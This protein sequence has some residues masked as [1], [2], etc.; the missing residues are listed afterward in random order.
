MVVSS[1]GFCRRGVRGSRRARTSGGIDILLL[2]RRR[3]PPEHENLLVDVVR[4][5][6][7]KEVSL[8]ENQKKVIEQEKSLNN[9]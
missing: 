3:E 7:K 2:Q 8:E 1:G 9:P 4:G 6:L 5:I